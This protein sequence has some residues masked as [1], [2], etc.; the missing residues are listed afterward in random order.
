MAKNNMN[1]IYA[2]QR[3]R[4]EK[5]VSLVEQAIN[6][7]SAGQQRISLTTIVKASKNI[8]PA[9]KG[10][11]ASTILRNKQ[12]HALYKRHEVPK[13]GHGNQKSRSVL[14]AALDDPT[15]SELR[16]AHL[17]EGKSK[18]SLIAAIISLERE[19]KSSEIQNGNLREKILSLLLSEPENRTD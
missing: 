2:W 5:S 15:A 13:H 1:G 4:I 14:H 17:L 6:E 9:G 16:R 3:G 12:C 10:V 19:L 7:L 11:S 8:D 18:T